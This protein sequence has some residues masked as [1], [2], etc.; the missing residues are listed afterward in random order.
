M[1]FVCPIPCISK[2]RVGSSN[3]LGRA[4]NLNIFKIF[5]INGTVKSIISNLI[6]WWNETNSGSK[7]NAINPVPETKRKIEI[8]IYP[9]HGPVIVLF[10]SLGEWVF[11]PFSKTKNWLLG[12]KLNIINFFKFGPKCFEIY[13]NTIKL[14]AD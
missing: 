8:K 13:W 2:P 5:T 3:P 14:F 9:S 4:N 10:R 11:K 7:S 1:S 12:Q 6:I